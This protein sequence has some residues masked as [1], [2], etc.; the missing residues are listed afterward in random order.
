MMMCPEDREICI[1]SEEEKQG[2]GCWLCPKIQDMR[3]SPYDKEVN[4]DGE[5]SSTKGD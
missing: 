2:M 5:E 3:E 4:K 1:M